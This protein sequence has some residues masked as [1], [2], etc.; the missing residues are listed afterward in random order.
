[1]TAVALPLP[2][3]FFFYGDAKLVVS[4]V[5]IIFCVVLR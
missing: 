2:T 5:S 4:V 3:L 1:M